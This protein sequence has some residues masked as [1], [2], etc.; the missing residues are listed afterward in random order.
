M[1][2][3]NP[4]VTPESSLGGHRFTFINIFDPA[5]IKAEIIVS[6]IFIANM[7][8]TTKSTYSIEFLTQSFVIGISTLFV[9]GCI[10]IIRGNTKESRKPP[11][12]KTDFGAW[13]YIW[14]AMAI[15]YLYM[16]ILLAIF[17]PLHFYGYNFSD[18]TKSIIGIAGFIFFTPMLVILLFCNEKKASF[19]NTVNM[20]RGF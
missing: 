16:L 15:E 4:Y 3:E 1:E 19:I 12:G 18:I 14:R 13:S 9:L 7:F 2:N 10:K 20:L 5:L 8:L 17:M 6:I 11:Y